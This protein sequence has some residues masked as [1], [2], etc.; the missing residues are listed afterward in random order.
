VDQ[1]IINDTMDFQVGWLAQVTGV[2]AVG[3][4]YLKYSSVMNFTATVQTIHEQPIWALIS[5]D[6]YDT[7]GYPIGETAFWDYINATR[8]TCPFTGP[9]TT[10]T[11]GIYVYPN[12]IQ[13]IPTWTRVG[14]A[15]VIGYALTDWPRNGGT[16]WGPQSPTT[17][18][19]IKVS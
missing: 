10:T 6:S 1:V 5:V 19:T 11:G 12:L 16:P 15:S 3:A 14:T 8:A 7:Q 13:G 18:F 2:V 17:L 4:P 9:T